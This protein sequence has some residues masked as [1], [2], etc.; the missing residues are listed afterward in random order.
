M[1]RGNNL[2]ANLHYATVNHHLDKP[3]FIILLKYKKPIEIVDEHLDSHRNYL[4]ECYAKN[5]FVVSGPRN[6][7]TGG[8][9]ISQLTDQ[10]K[11]E[12]ILKDDPF[13]IHDVAD[14]EIIEFKPVQY[15]QDFAEFLK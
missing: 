9:L 7:R 13:Y 1:L 2:S 4:Q 8:V 10:A 11:V 5:Y 6:P 14:Y 12:D 15:H 3:M